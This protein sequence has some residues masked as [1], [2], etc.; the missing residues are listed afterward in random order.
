MPRQC[1]YIISELPDPGPTSYLLPFY[2]FDEL[3]IYPSKPPAVLGCF[4][5]H[6]D[7]LFLSLNELI[8]EKYSC[9]DGPPPSVQD[10]ILWSTS[11]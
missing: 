6:G 4:S 8:L 10:H 7:G 9:F 2:I 5:A 3:L 11:K 1:P